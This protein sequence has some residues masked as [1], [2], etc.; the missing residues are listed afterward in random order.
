MILDM[1]PHCLGWLLVGP[2]DGCD[3]KLGFNPRGT[4]STVPGLRTASVKDGKGMM[5]PS[6]FC[7][8]VQSGPWTVTFRSKSNIPTPDPPPAPNLDARQMKYVTS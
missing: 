7:P 8:S 2:S 5:A 6:G 4:D 1:G 3:R